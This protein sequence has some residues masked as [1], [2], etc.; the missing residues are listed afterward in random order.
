MRSPGLLLLLASWVGL[1]AQT[2]TAPT[3]TYSN[4]EFTWR[5]HRELV[6]AG[7]NEN[8]VW[9]PLSL[10]AVLAVLGEGA[11]G[12]TAEECG[13]F[14]GLPASA[15]RPGDAARPWD[16]AAVHQANRAAVQALCAPWSKPNGEEAQRMLDQT[17]DPLSR[18]ERGKLDQLTTIGS[19]RLGPYR[20]F[21][22]RSVNRLWVQSGLPLEADHL[23]VIRGWY[24]Q[25]LV[26]VADFKGQPAAERLRLNLWVERETEGLIKNF[27]GNDEWSKET[28]LAVTNVVTLRSDWSSRFDPAN[29]RRERFYALGESAPLG[30][31]TM[32]QDGAFRYAAFNRDGTLFATPDKV[33][34]TANDADPSFYPNQGG[35]HLVELPYAG[36]RASMVLVQPTRLGRLIELEAKLSSAQLLGM[37]DSG[38]ER[39][40]LVKLPRFKTRSSTPL[41]APAARLGL[42]TLAKANDADLTGLC[43]PPDHRDRLFLGGLR[44]TADIEVNEMGTVAV[45]ATGGILGGLGGPPPTRP[46]VPQFIANQAFL[47]FIKDNETGQILFMGRM[48]NPTK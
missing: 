12:Q 37:F 47:Y 10:Q 41:L 20:P 32:Q 22:F 34:A 27:V 45:A 6:R 19:D 8:L 9:S 29:T 4:V 17:K 39:R 15:R 33:P 31:P 18:S 46:F 43:A 26:A 38:K 2:T 36:Q 42:V 7:P 24:G 16:F 30:V 28:R 23:A 44:Q 40:C 13:A 5:L 14:L 1:G 3:T 11:R 48:M 21:L 35:Y 25:G